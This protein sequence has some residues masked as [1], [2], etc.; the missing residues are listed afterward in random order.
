MEYLVSKRMNISD[1]YNKRFSREE[2]KKRKVLWKTLNEY[3]LYQWI[4]PS[5]TVCDIGAGT[6]E[7]L[8]TANAKKKIAVDL[9]YPTIADKRGILCYPSIRHIP[10][11]LHGQVDVVMLS[12]VLEHVETREEI[13]TI[14][15]RIKKLLKPGGSLLIIQ[16]VIELVGNR[17]WDFFDHIV[18]ITRKSL[19]EALAMEGYD[20]TVFIPRFLPY[21]TKAGLPVNTFLL[22]MYLLIPWYFRPFAGQCFIRARVAR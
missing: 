11:T 17:Y 21:T 2:Q 5:N 14:L 19:Q 6:R 20:V 7:F 4:R 12:N 16:P 15:R 9:Q 18:P 3:F 10:K 1:L 22:R 8:E 13:L